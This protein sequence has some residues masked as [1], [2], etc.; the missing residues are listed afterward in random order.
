MEDRLSYV[1]RHRRLDTNEVFYVGKGTRRFESS[2]CYGRSR[3]KNGRNKFWKNIVKKTQYATEIIANHLTEYEAH[4]LEEFLISLYG[5]RDLRQGTLANL[6]D[7]GEG[8]KG[9][10]PQY[11]KILSEDQNRKMMEAR[12]DIS[13]CNNPRAVSV[14]DVITLEIF[15]TLKLAAQEHGIST[16]IL[17]K[18]LKRKLPNQT[19]LMLLEEYERG[20]SLFKSDKRFTAPVRVV[21]TNTMIIYNSIKEASVVVGINSH[22]LSLKL[23]NK[24]PNN[25]SMLLFSEYLDTEQCP[26]KK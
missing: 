20:M 19:N 26:P 9:H 21:D 23:R 11:V 18:Y 12:G 10:V 25:T 8:L 6:T 2:K 15:C 24:K 13:G 14:I 22:L 5:R 3:D 17:R 4:E 16:T 1:Y 7:G